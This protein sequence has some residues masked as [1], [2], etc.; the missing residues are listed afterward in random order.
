MPSDGLA[1]CLDTSILIS[2]SYNYPQPIF[3]TL[4]RYLDDLVDS[5][6]LI[7]IEQIVREY[8]RNDYVANWLRGQSGMIRSLS[9]EAVDCL[10]QLMSD[11]PEFVDPGKTDPDADQPLVAFAMA[12]NSSPPEGLFSSRLAVVTTERAK[13]PSERRLR[14]PDVCAYYGIECFDHFEMMRREGW[15]F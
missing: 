13:K 12:Y 15:E 8:T 2:L 1:F 6:R 5:G 10:A 9:Q 14:I 7:T 4:W 3:K 11:L